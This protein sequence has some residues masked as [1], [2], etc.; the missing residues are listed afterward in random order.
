[1]SN[2]SI[3]KEFLQHSHS[4]YPYSINLP[5]R[6]E[7]VVVQQG[8]INLPPNLKIPNV[9]FIREIKFNLISLVQ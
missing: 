2:H 6:A 8:N 7:V 3:R 5:N 9:L 4:I 1:M